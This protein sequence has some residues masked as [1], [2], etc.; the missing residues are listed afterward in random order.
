MNISFVLGS[1]HNAAGYALHL[2]YFYLLGLATLET[3]PIIAFCVS[4]SLSAR[5]CY[6]FWACAVPLRWTTS[7]SE[8][9]STAQWL[10]IFS[11]GDK[12]WKG[13]KAHS[14]S[15]DILVRVLFICFPLDIENSECLKV[16]SWY[17]FSKLAFL[18]LC[19]VL[20]R[21]VHLC[22]PQ[23]IKRQMYRRNTST[24]KVLTTSM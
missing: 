15:A 7:D 18:C 4:P 23:P 13:W 2:A 16:A 24:E 8:H 11:L 10:D 3:I 14:L 6:P 9:T 17:A 1:F 19:F 12:R 20:L 21:S 5:L 22:L